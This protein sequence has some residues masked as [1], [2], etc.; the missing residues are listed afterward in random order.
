MEMSPHGPG[1]GAAQCPQNWERG[2]GGEGDGD[3]V[4]GKQLGV[5][6]CS[7]DTLEIYHLVYSYESP[8]SK[9]YTLK[10]SCN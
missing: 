9:T 4:L 1:A 2:V 8:F 5:L 10:F 7:G 3:T 6:N